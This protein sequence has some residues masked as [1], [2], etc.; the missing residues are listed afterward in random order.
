MFHSKCTQ[1]STYVCW[2]VFNNFVVLV[3]A[4]FNCYTINWC[5]LL[6]SW[7][8]VLSLLKDIGVQMANEFFF[9]FS[10]IDKKFL[11]IWWVVF[12][13]ALCFV[14]IFVDIQINVCRL[15]VLQVVWQGVVLFDDLSKY[16]IHLSCLF[17]CY[18]V[19]HCW[20]FNL[21]CESLV[22][23]LIHDLLLAVLCLQQVS[24]DAGRQSAK[25]DKKFKSSSVSRSRHP[26]LQLYFWYPIA[27]QLS[28]YDVKIH[29]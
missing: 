25:K 7:L 1:P 27:Y 22:T 3:A 9:C 6:L 17:I 29:C 4:H 26:L 18:M 19:F 8:A 14:F 12:R 5:M 2:L 13:Y 23:Y 24:R 11:F 28:L 21:V 15:Y 20:L 16:I 10:F